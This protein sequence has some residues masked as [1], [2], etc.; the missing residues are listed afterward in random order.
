V[1][2]LRTTVAALDVHRQ[3]N[4]TA[5][6]YPD[7]STL[8][9]LFE[10]CA[11]EFPGRIAIVCGSES[12]TY[13]ELNRLANGLAARLADM[14]IASGQCV[15]VYSERSSE[16]IVSLLAI[17]KCGASYL[18]IDPSWPNHL[19]DAIMSSFG[20]GLVLA[21]ERML[22]AAHVPA[23]RRAVQVDL[24]RL[25]LVDVNPH[26]VTDT[27][28]IAYVNFT[29][30][31]TGTPKGV[32]IQH[33]S[34]ARLVFD[35]VYAPLDHTSVLLHVSPVTFDAAT[36]EIWGALLRGG[37]CVLYPSRHLSFSRLK[38]VIERGGVTVA[39]VTTALFNAII[40]EAPATLDTVSTILTGGERYSYRHIAAALERY[41]PGRVVHVYGPTECTTFATYY[42]I[43]RMPD[44]TDELPIGRPIQ[45]TRLYVV[46][47]NRLCPPGVVG[48]I[49]LA[50]PGLSPGYLGADQTGIASFSEYVIQATTERVYR[51]GD[52]GYLLDSGELVFAGRR[53]DQIKVNGFRIKL[54]ELSQTLDGHPNVKQSYVTVS[55]GETGERLL[56]AFVVP[57]DGQ[58]TAAELREYIRGRLPAYMIPSIVCCHERLPLTAN[59]K[60]DRQALLRQTQRH[61]PHSAPE[62]QPADEG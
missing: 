20:C 49:M 11:T 33:R 39:F 25:P 58:M 22:S 26:A 61:F 55:E 15:A 59:G 42:P 43:Y 10:R 6:P 35:A 62:G 2:E 14:G 41:G 31:T 7:Q 51:T 9:E 44:K 57:L 34:I 18:P 28:A 23:D 12:V 16:M 21:G 19:L 54:A 24:S 17:T 46:S 3:I 4:R 48:E 38:T 47:E 32:P 40:D 37:T 1:Q 30:G 50:G 8:K 5:R 29:S 53:D 36:F 52:F 60:V 27:A 13:R 56:S 45:N